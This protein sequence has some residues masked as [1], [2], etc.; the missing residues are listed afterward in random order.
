MVQERTVWELPTLAN[1]D[2]EFIE[3]EVRDGVGYLRLNRAPVNAHNLQMILELDRAMLHARF[4]DDARVIVLMSAR[5]NYF[6]AGA[7]IKV[8]RDEPPHRVGLLSQTS[9]EVILRARSIPKIFIAAIDGHCM[10]GGLELAFACDLRFASQGGWKLG[11]PELSLGVMPGEGGSQLL[12]RVVGP[13]RALRLMLDN[14]V[15]GV[16]EA[17]EM[18]IVDRVL[19][20]EGFA[21]AIHEYAKNVANG[22]RGAIGATKLALTEGLEMPLP[23]GFS[24]ERMQQ[25]ELL[26]RDDSREGAKAFLEKR[27]PRWSEEW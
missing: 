15:F 23:A 19:P 4:D 14:E 1:A 11:M 9:K 6:S 24:F 20:R 21:D 18:G 2:L 8:I 16:E 13:S 27:P 7:D 5:E 17:K 25:N 12:G 22:P 26:R 10:G 3:T